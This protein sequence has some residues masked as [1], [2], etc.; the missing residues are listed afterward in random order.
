MDEKEARFILE[1]WIESDNS[2]YTGAGNP[3]IHWNSKDKEKGA[4]L[5]GNF[6]L[7]ELKAI[8]WW[9]ENKQL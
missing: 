4:V 9:M 6:E 8:V 3:Y 7:N 5:D 2:L 1:R